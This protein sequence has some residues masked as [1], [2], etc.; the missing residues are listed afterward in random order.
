M[1]RLPLLLILVLTAVTTTILFLRHGAHGDE[2]TGRYLALLAAQ[3][4]PGAL[5]APKERADW[6]TARVFYRGKLIEALGLDLLPD[7]PL[8]QRTV[9]EQVFDTYRVSRLMFD[10]LPDMHG[11]ADLYLPAAGAAPFPAVL[12]VASAD[13]GAGEAALLRTAVTLAAA[14]A[15]TLVLEL[16]G[17]GDRHPT[18]RGDPALFLSGLTP[19]GLAVWE[20]QRLLDMLRRR[21]DIDPRRIAVAGAGDGGMTALY[22]AAL[23]D[24]VAAGATL[25]S[26]GRFGAGTGSPVLSELLLF[27]RRD[28]EQHHILALVAP[29]PFLVIAGKKDAERTAAATETVRRARE[30]YRFLGGDERLEF[31]VAPGAHRYQP[32]HRALLYDFLTRHLGTRA[33]REEEQEPEHVPFALPFAPAQEMTLAEFARRETL[34]LR[35]ELRERRD[36]GGPALYA[37]ELAESLRDLSGAGLFH[38]RIADLPLPDTLLACTA[39][40]RA[41]AAVIVLKGP[42]S[43]RMT[44]TLS[45]ARVETCE[46]ATGD[47]F[48]GTAADA[49][50]TGIPLAFLRADDI[51]TVATELSRKGYAAVGLYAEGTDDALAALLAAH[52]SDAIGWIAL[53]DAALSLVPGAGIP[54]D[55]ERAALAAPRLLR[56]GDIGDLIAALAPRRILLAGMH[57][58]DRAPLDPAAVRR[59]VW[60]TRHLVID[61]AGA[62]ETLHRFLATR[63]TTPSP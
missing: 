58:P 60:E 28:L 33:M 48:S 12:F 43:D 57:G 46:L 29:R 36:D 53:R 20:T 31:A 22:T 34:L 10:S 14:G 13:E 2:R 50:V 1:K 42:H 9:G 26:L 38:P 37:V 32:P 4:P 55:I 24:R 61:P 35:E 40:D 62:E 49:L 19:A 44:K 6:E 52:R 27:P 21:S 15:A 8:N 7:R 47:L 30:I 11:L 56:S 59:L 45:E 5:P 23:D 16:P 39:P 17:R 51:I 18:G 54:D 63:G 25:L 3:E 41:A